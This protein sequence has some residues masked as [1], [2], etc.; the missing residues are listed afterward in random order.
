MQQRNKNV[1]RVLGWCRTYGI[2]S[3]GIGCV[4]GAAHALFSLLFGYSVWPLAGQAAVAGAAVSAFLSL[5]P[6]I[7]TRFTRRAIEEMR[8][9]QTPQLRLVATPPPLAASTRRSRRGYTL[10]ELLL[11]I[12]V[13]FGGI[14]GLLVGGVLMGNFW[15]TEDGALACAKFANPSVVRV[16]KL[17]R[18]I[19]GSGTIISEDNGGTRHVFVL[20]TNVLGNADCEEIE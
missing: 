11:T 5:R 6:Q 1:D 15:I 18:G 7:P 8:T 3:L 16:A 9:R 2:L 10:L 4:V 12:I 19:W 17:E 14:G 20:D 13:L